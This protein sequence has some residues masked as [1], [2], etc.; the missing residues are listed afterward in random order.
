MS[1]IMKIGIL[2]FHWATNYGAVLQAY[3]LQ[4]YL[5]SIG[6]SVEVINYK[7]GIYDNGLKAALRCL[8]NNKFDEYLVM[9]KKEKSLDKFRQSYLHLKE[10]IYSYS[11]LP[12]F[13]SKFDCI[14]S[15]SDQ[16]MNPSFLSNG[17]GKKCPSPAYYIGFPFNGKR[18]AYAVSFGCVTFPKLETNIASNYIVA[19]DKISTREC[20]GI[21]IVNSMGRSDAIVVPDPTILLDSIQYQELAQHTSNKIEEPFIYCFFIRNITERRMALSSLSHSYQLLWNNNDKDYS[22][23]GW[24]S[25][26]QNAKFVITDSFHCIVMCLKLHT[27]FVVITDHTG[28]FGMNDRFYT[29]LKKVCLEDRIIHKDQIN[30]ILQLKHIKNEWTDVDR[31][32]DEYKLKG[33]EFL[34]NI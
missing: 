29:L 27:P 1:I 8:K 9:W 23:E 6:H 5:E 20:T 2:T 30:E 12:Q 34:Q 14:I 21:D 16:V 26:I 10:R 18:V 28:N 31:L 11:D 4:T 3:A 24:L 19:F 15:G 25:K 17:E 13:T 7:P 22:L 32:L 33:V